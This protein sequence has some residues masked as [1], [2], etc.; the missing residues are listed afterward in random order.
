[1]QD[2][3]LINSLKARNPTGFK[4][5]VQTFGNRVL[6]IG[7]KFLLNRED[8]EDIAQEV[9]IE[10]FQS[11][12][13]FRH[14]AKLSTWLYRIAVTKCLDAL[15]KRKRKKRL[16][17]MGKMLQL[18]DIAHVLVGDFAADR[19]LLEQDD[20]QEIAEALNVLPDNQRVAFTLSKIEGYTNPEIAEIMG[21]TTVAVESLVYRAKK[22]MH[23][24]LLKI[25]R[26][27]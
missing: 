17:E 15:K 2:E 8:A 27:Y 7:Y 20:L 1:M 19:T 10:V 6:A 25:L 13:S 14:D 21:T 3:E 26:G 9:F 12:H 18:E 16:I 22:Q 11:I 24:T 4:E 5:L 23:D